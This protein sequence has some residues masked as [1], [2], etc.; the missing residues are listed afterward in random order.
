[1]ACF[2]TLVTLLAVMALVV[3]ILALLLHCAVPPRVRLRES[4]LVTAGC[5]SASL[6]AVIAALLVIFFAN[7]SEG[8]EAGRVP[9]LLVGAG[10]LLWYVGQVA[11]VVYLRRV[12]LHF[13]DRRLAGD[14]GGFLIVLLV[15]V[16]LVVFGE[17]V[18]LSQVR[19]WTAD[20]GLSIAVFSL[21]VPV[22][23]L[24]YWFATLV[25]RLRALIPQKPQEVAGA[26]PD[27]A[28]ASLKEEPSP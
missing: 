1:M 2:L 5:V 24:I 27:P 21:Q 16:P 4:A 18:L 8:R 19:R 11:H 17:I 20:V 25:A 6:L 3:M 12:A 26:A 23:I 10:L 28:A 7:P 9:T 22:P 13:G 14:L 15:F